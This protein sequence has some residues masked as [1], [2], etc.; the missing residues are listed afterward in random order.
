MEQGAAVRRKWVAEG[1][2]IGKLCRGCLEQRST[3]VDA[4]RRRLV[5][6]STS[7]SILVDPK[8]SD[9]LD[10]RPGVGTGERDEEQR[11]RGPRLVGAGV[12]PVYRHHLSRPFNNVVLLT[13]YHH[14]HGVTILLS[15][16]ASS[17]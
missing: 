10:I 12:Y 5:Q 2:Y 6:G 17:R 3:I 4:M 13:S 8:A 9:L 11:P 16:G 15:S 14:H 1:T 7:R